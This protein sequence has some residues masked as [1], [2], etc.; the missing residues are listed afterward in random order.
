MLSGREHEGHVS[1]ASAWEIAAK[2][3][4]GKLGI[5]LA[6]ERF[7]ELVA[8]DGFAHLPIQAAHG[9]RA[10]TYPQAHLDPFDR[11]L[12]AQAE[13]DGLKL[14]TNDPALEAFPAERLW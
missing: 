4:L 5:P 6:S 13:I 2:A 1:A 11:M 9:L 10:G 8:L 3:R 14:V 7:A 12:A